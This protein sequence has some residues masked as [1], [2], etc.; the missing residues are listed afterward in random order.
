MLTNSY[1]IR[2]KKGD[3]FVSPIFQIILNDVVFD[4]SDV[5]IKITLKKSPSQSL[6]VLVFEE[7]SEDGNQVEKIDAVNGRFL[8]TT[9]E[10]NVEAGS[11]IYEARFTKADGTVKTYF[12]GKFMI[13]DD[14]S[15]Y[16]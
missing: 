7:N 10:L 1:N 12:A 4:L 11:Y 3:T 8:F 16:S 15:V 5:E 14:V 6:P 9:K 2:A 13:Y